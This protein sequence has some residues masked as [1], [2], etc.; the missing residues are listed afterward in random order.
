MEGYQKSKSQVPANHDKLS[1]G[2]VE[3]LGALKDD[4]KAYSYQ[5]I[6]HP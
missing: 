5:G 1:L 4:H 3:R 6:D 2:N